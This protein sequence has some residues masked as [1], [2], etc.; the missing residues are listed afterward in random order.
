MRC[1][2]AGSSSE[3]Y[4]PERVMMR[5]F[6]PT[7]RRLRGSR[8]LAKPQAASDDDGGSDQVRA[9]RLYSIPYTLY[10]LYT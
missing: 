1:A 2:A 8:T 10:T 5:E 3:P 4:H 7:H 6:Q 9:V